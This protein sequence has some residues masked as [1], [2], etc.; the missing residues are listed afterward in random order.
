ME[1]PSG[2]R[3]HSQGAFHGCKTVLWMRGQERDR[4]NGHVSMCSQK[5]RD[6]AFRIGNQARHMRREILYIL[7]PNGL[8]V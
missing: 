5:L 1:P 7:L 2:D 4:G 6:R 3:R 8:C